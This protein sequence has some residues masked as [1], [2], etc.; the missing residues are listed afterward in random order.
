MVNR[1]GINNHIITYVDEIW[2]CFDDTILQVM[3]FFYLRTHPVYVT[4]IGLRPSIRHLNFFLLMKRGTGELLLL[5]HSGLPTIVFLNQ[6]QIPFV[7]LEH[8]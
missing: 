5:G 2:F 1:K 8:P 3:A 6:W 7:L 4:A